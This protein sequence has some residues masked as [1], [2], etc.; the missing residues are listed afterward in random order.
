MGLRVLVVVLDGVGIGALPDAAVYGDEG[1]HTLGN[2]ARAVGGLSLPHLED[3]GLGHTAEIR[4]VPPHP[5]PRGAYGRMAARSPAKDSITGH[6]ELMGL[7]LSKPFPTYPQGF[8]EEIIKAFEASIGR[9]TLG[10]IPASG[11]EIIKQLGVEHLKTGRPIVYTSADSV[12]QVAAHESVIPRE[13][14]YKICLKAR[15]LL[16]GEHAVARVIARPFVGEPGSFYRTGGRR[17]FSLPPPD[18]TLLDRLKEAG[19]PVVGIGKV[20]DLFAGRGLT[21][22]LHT[23]SNE[24]GVECAIRELEALE[25][26]LILLNLCDFDTL[27]GHR[28]DPRGFAQALEAFDKRVPLLGAHLREDDLCIITGDHG[29]DPTTASTDHSREYVP[30]LITGPRI[31]PVDLG[32]RLTLADLGQTLAEAFRV[33]RLKSGDSFFKDLRCLPGP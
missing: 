18:E 29:N 6:W 14:L 33:G 25:D 15:A 9:G 26:G 8:P 20:E 31:H 12:F 27:Y 4:G 11:T 3:L 7:V 16:Q 32:T 13:E 19:I 10:N 2:L 21:K 30:L 23:A 22:S 1:S 28:N 24:E 17:D 5:R